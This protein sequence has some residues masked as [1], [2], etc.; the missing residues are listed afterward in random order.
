M[1]LTDIIC[2]STDDASDLDY[3]DIDDTSSEECYREA[4]S[5]KELDVRLI[6]I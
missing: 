4:E 3:I 2:D 6:L 5:D 1:D